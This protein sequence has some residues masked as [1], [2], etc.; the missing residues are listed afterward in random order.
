MGSLRGRIEMQLR[1]LRSQ[2]PGKL[3]RNI[4]GPKQRDTYKACARTWSSPDSPFAISSSAD[5][6]LVG[7]IGELECIPVHCIRLSKNGSRSSAEFSSQSLRASGKTC[8]T[9]DMQSACGRATNG[10]LRLRTRPGGA[11]YGV[12]SNLVFFRAASFGNTNAFL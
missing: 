4:S 12:G 8:P 5:F 2:R 6:F 10:Q 3:H 1:L 11:T 9:R 7:S